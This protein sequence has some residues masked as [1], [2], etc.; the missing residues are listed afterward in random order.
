MKNKNKQNI[1]Q[2]SILMPLVPLVPFQ[3]VLL[4]IYTVLVQQHT[5]NVYKTRSRSS[6]ENLKTEL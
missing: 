4:I 1:V 6:K 2:L 3:I 5:Q